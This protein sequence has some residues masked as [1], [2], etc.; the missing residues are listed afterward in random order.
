[1]LLLARGGR[2]KIHHMVDKT[3]NLSAAQRGAHEKYTKSNLSAMKRGGIRFYDLSR[4]IWGSGRIQ[5]VSRET[6]G[7]TWWEN[8]SGA[9]WELMHLCIFMQF[10][11]MHLLKNSRKKVL[12][13]KIVQIT[14][15]RLSYRNVNALQM[16]SMLLRWKDFLLNWKASVHRNM[17]DL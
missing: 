16:H 3:D 9:A 15:C 8:K 5:H 17:Q 4:R 13:D 11:F 2:R 14:S 12:V 7:L 6:V 1:M 10:Y